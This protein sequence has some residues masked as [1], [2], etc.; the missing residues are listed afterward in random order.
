ML[1]DTRIERLLPSQMIAKATLV[2][3]LCFAASISAAEVWTLRRA[4]EFGIEN[5]PDARIAQQRIAAADASL[6]QANSAFW[7]K[8]QLHSSY[9]RTDNPMMAFG[10][11]LNQRAFDPS[12]NFNNVPETDAINVRGVISTPLYAGGKNLAERNAAKSTRRASKLEQVAVRNQLEFEIVRAFLVIHSAR[13]LTD[14]VEAAAQSFET[15]LALAQRRF[16]N[17]TVLKAD[18]LDIE[19]RL[20]ETKENLVRARN[21]HRLAKRALQNLLGVE[22]DESFSV[23][24]TIP[25]LASPREQSSERPELAALRHRED[26]GRARVRA[27]KSG[28]MPR[29]NAFGSADY[30][31]GTITRG[32]GASYAAGVVV[33]WDLWDGFSTRSKIT[34][35]EVNL[36][37]VQEEA[38]KVRL[39]VELELEQARSNLLAAQERLTATE[40]AVAHATE[41]VKLTRDRF[42]QGLALST[43]IIDAEIALLAARI[44]R[45]DAESDEQLAIAALRKAL[46]LPQLE[47]PN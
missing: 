44:R 45:T 22:N 26:A 29:V 2:S 1:R 27:A 47:G 36:E 28:Y 13:R 30:D 43:Q 40:S 41:S 39:A 21:S 35:A 18:V 5:N 32:D 16:Q 10:N 42:E 38:R 11:I 12:L 31:Y 4:L 6:Q 37:T 25:R 34:E 33:H 23:D 46:A 3:V 15:N 9:T 20:A 8:A 19:V 24:E 17:G 14:S 7:P